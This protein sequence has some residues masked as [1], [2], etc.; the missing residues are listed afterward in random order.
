MKMKLFVLPALLAASA[1]GVGALSPERQ[2]LVTY[3]SDTPDSTMNEAKNAIEA[4]VSL[5]AKF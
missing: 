2:V 4:A 5:H 1:L 3:P